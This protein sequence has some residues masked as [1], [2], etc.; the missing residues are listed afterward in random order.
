MELLNIISNDISFGVLWRSKQNPR[1]WFCYVGWSSNLTEM[2]QHY[3]EILKSPD[4]IQA[5]IV[6]RTESIQPL[7]MSEAVMESPNESVAIIEES[8]DPQNAN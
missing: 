4:C 5:C 2:L 8:E 3:Q 6:M 1:D 7:Q